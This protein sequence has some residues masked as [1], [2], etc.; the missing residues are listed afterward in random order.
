MKVL[1]KE[2]EEAHY[3]EVLKGGTIG[4]ALGLAFGG[5][6]LSLASRRYAM[7]RNLT[8]PG[9]AFLISS[10]TTFGLIINADRYSEKYKLTTNPMYGY[11][12][13]TSVAL[14]HARANLSGT[15][16]FMA[17]G[18]EN[19]YSIVFGSWLASMGAAF[20]I[21]NR[22]KYMSGAQKLVQARVYAQ[23]LTVAVLVLTAIFEM[24]DAKKGSG[25]W[26][27]VMVEDPDD[28]EH[29]LVEKKIHKEEYEGQD[30][31]KGEFV[32]PLRSWFG[33]V[34]NVW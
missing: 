27:T 9:K 28:P 30:L 7:I 24:N 25:R 14:E 31:W 21:V 15:D 29:K 22:S 2:Q 3:Q 4:G 16:R 33:R 17:W 20:A 12:D 5:L 10:S 23:G 32:A 6:A 8:V 13:K 18:R 11:K 26:Q 19:R 34:A 1:T